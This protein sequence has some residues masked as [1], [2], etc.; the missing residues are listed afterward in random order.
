MAWFIGWF[1]I[2]F[3]SLSILF[4]IL[5]DPLSLWEATAS[6]K[7]NNPDANEPSDAEFTSRRALLVT[8]GV[9]LVFFGFGAKPYC[10]RKPVGPE[11]L[12][13]GV[14]DCRTEIG[15]LGRS[16]YRWQNRA[17]GHEACLGQAEHRCDGLCSR[18]PHPWLPGGRPFGR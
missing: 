15:H 16:R 5:V 1:Q 4:G 18:R 2:C 17:R 8:S 13:R 10:D 12:S 6:R 14:G 11:Q 3:G 7:Y 9:V